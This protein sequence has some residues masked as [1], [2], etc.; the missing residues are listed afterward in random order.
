[1]AHA[2]EN[3]FF[4][5]FAAILESDATS[6]VKGAAV[7]ILYHMHKGKME[8]WPSIARIAKLASIGNRTV[9]DHLPDLKRWFDIE[10]TAPRQP[11]H[12]RAKIEKAAIELAEILEAKRNPGAPGASP[13][14]REPHYPGAGAAS[15]LVRG[16]HPNSQSE[17]SR[18]LP[19]R[20]L[21]VSATMRADFSERHNGSAAASN[22]HARYV[23]IL[24]SEGRNV[25]ERLRCADRNRIL[26]PHLLHQPGCLQKLAELLNHTEADAI[27]AYG[28]EFGTVARGAAVDA[29]ANKLCG[30]LTDFEVKPRGIGTWSYFVK[31]I[32][33][34]VEKACARRH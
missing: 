19:S 5:V 13:L 33:E 26:G 30:A 18:E 28:P 6:H 24:D 21:K 25:I 16:A 11:Y 3:P 8:A 17:L 27:K 4:T 7:A 1:M 2:H 23:E 12:F 31:A 10:A 20:T 14:V 15:P 34:E 9:Q 29:I 22:G 32:N